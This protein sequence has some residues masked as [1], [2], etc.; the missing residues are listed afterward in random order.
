[1]SKHCCIL[2]FIENVP[3]TDEDDSRSLAVTRWDTRSL[4]HS[5]FLNFVLES[6]V[7]QTSCVF[8]SLKVHGPTQWFEKENGDGRF[9]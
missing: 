7:F 4:V 1:M 9:V 8:C 2:H 6:D 5:L 3:L